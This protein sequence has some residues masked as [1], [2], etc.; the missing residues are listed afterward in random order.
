M[1]LLVCG[2]RVARSEVHRH[3]HGH[4]FHQEGHNNAAELLICTTHCLLHPSQGGQTALAAPHL[5]PR[6]MGGISHHM[7][8]YLTRNL[9][10]ELYLTKGSSGKIHVAS[11]HP[12]RLQFA[13]EK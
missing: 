11:A 6:Q 10:S 13:A 12:T 5:P 4:S 7:E 9:S 8:I 2:S 1:Y 3:L